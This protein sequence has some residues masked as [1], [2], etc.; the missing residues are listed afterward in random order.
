MKQTDQPIVSVVI[1]SY[2]RAEV[3]QRAVDSVL[4]QTMQDIEVIVVDDNGLGTPAGLATAEKMQKYA[5]DSRVTYLQHEVNK[6]GSAARNTGIR[7]AKGKYIAFLDDDDA[8]LPQR[9]EKMCA[10]MEQL[11]ESWGACYSGYVKHM[12][13]GGEQ[14]SAEKNEGDLFLQALMRS[15]YIG[16]GSNLFFRRSAVEKVGLF[17]ESYRRNQ[18]LEYLVRILKE[19]KIAYVDDVLFEI[20]FDIRTDESTDAQRLERETLFRKNFAHHLENLSKKEKRAV[21][22]MY[23]LDWIRA[24]IN[25]RKFGDA[26]KTML[27]ARI[28][29]YVYIDYFKY[30]VDRS[31]NHLS[32]GFVVKIR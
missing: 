24:C 26:V 20:F 15:L 23:E 11:D 10:R 12:P 16:S 21:L 27:R 14:Y 6:N 29:L 4:N 1:P 28:P 31:K 13:N 9:F 30:A 22:C 5:G 32:Y 2:K 8:Y 7:A 25:H 3:I 17:D 19:Y 18:D